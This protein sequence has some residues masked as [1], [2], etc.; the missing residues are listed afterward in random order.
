[1]I[2]PERKMNGYPYTDVIDFVERTTYE[3]WNDK[4]PDLVPKWYLP[5]TVIWTDVGDIIGDE[6]VTRDT[7][8]RRKGFS[9]YYG[10]IDDTI[11]TGDDES[12]YRTSMRWIARGTHDGDSPVGPPTGR[13][14]VNSSISHCVIR[15]DQYVEE[16]AGGNSKAF[17]DQLGLPL[18]E[19]IKNAGS[20][21]APRGEKAREL[22]A[23]FGV[24]VP[25]IPDV[26]DGPGKVVAD[27]LD[28][29]YNKRDLSLTD[30][31][32]APGAPYSFGTTRLG[33]GPAGARDEV[34]RWLELLPDLALEIEELYWNLDGEDSG[35]VAVRYQI[36]GTAQNDAGQSRPVSLMGF[37]HIHVRG[38]RVVAEWVEYNELALLA[39]IG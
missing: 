29:L 12:G 8:A 7:W 36:S 24:S 6:A 4:Q 2:H 20:S 27:L 13:R 19:A 23:S 35:R 32:Y 17:I 14:V 11:W 3:I 16:W 18:N 5:E 31:T 34:S 39:Q 10:I 37:H 28:G 33:F 21:R 1:M 22:T 30:S 9:D 15:G 25:A 38:Q 26:I